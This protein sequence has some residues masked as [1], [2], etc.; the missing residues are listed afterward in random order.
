MVFVIKHWLITGDTHGGINTIVRLTKAKEDFPNCAPE[1]TAIVVLGDCS[2]NF[3]LNNTDK[4]YKKMINNYGYQLFLVKG[5]H[6]EDPANISTMSIVYN[7]EVNNE[8]YEEEAYPNIHYFIDGYEYIINNHSVLVVGGAYSID[9]EMRLIRAGY[10]LAEAEIA[11][12]KKCGWF[13]DECLSVEKRNEILAACKGKSY[14]FVLSHTC[15]ICWEPYD[16]FLS[17]IDQSKVDKSME[18]FLNNLKEKVNWGCW[19][20][21]HYHHDRYERPHVEQFFE[22]FDTLE[23]VAAR[24]KNW[25]ETGSLENYYVEKSPM[26]YAEEN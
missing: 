26:F 6:E 4:K 21:G 13:K 2:I 16:L 3:Y 14:D 17:F 8:V 9:K 1:E 23:A 11:D 15:P 25:D 19:L 24:W 10:S 5:N 18:I 20:F 7:N 12:P 22:H